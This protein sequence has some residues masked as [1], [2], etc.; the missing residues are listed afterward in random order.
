MIPTALLPHRARLRDSTRHWVIGHPWSSNRIG[1]EESM[2]FYASRRTRL[3]D[4]STESTYPVISGNLAPQRSSARRCGERLRDFTS[5]MAAP[6]RRLSWHRNTTGAITK[7]DCQHRP[8]GHLRVIVFP[9]GPARRAKT[10]PCPTTCSVIW[11]E[12]RLIPSPRNGV[13][14]LAPAAGRPNRARRCQG[15]PL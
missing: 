10:A 1:C 3:G 4:C 13:P 8:A 9:S 11:G 6:D 7:A 12:C 2:V 5:T 14:K 15:R